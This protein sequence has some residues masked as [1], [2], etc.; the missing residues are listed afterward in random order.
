MIFQIWSCILYQTPH[1]SIVFKSKYSRFHKISFVVVARSQLC[2]NF[3]SDTFFIKF[4]IMIFLRNVCL[5]VLLWSLSSTGATTI[6]HDH[7]G[8]NES[9]QEERSSITSSLLREEFAGF[10]R[11]VVGMEDTNHDQHFLRRELQSS[12]VCRPQVPLNVPLGDSAFCNQLPNYSCS[13]TGSTETTCTYCMI[14]PDANGL[15]CQV[16]GSSVTFRDD[17]G[18][19]TTCGC[20]YIG[21]GQVQQAC[22]QE[23]G[24]VPIPASAVVV[25]PPPPAPIAVRVPVPSPA[26]TI[27]AGQQSS[28]ST[29][30]GGKTSKSSKKR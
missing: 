14:R 2:S 24:P 25:A 29:S 17:T 20:E 30:T 10:D 18:V 21:N 26:A 12:I 5:L 9:E 6:V 4:L 28:G 8:Y 27:P 1:F 19:V 3:L 16:S 7:D 22:Y 15:R 23:S 11:L 13:C